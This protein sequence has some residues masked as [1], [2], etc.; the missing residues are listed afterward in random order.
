MKLLVFIIIARNLE[1]CSSF[2]IAVE[3]VSST[4]DVKWNSVLSGE[5][6]TTLVRDASIPILNRVLSGRV[7]TDSDNSNLQREISTDIIVAGIS[8]NNSRSS[9][10]TC[11][12]TTIYLYAVNNK[13]MQDFCSIFIVAIK[14]NNLI[15]I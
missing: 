15:F 10:S 9:S 4:D 6:T 14:I 5:S 12:T 3:T 11:A 13:L 8:R 2:H 7:L 1:V